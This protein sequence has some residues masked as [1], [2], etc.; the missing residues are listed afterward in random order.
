MIAIIIGDRSD[1]AQWGSSTW[2]GEANNKIDNSKIKIM[3]TD[4]M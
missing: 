1:S 2:G 3:E 4:R